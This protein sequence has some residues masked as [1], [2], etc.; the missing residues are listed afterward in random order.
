MKLI[1]GFW[2]DENNN[3]W[4]SRYY[5]EID[6]ETNSNSLTD[7]ENCIDCENCTECIDCRNC[8]NCSYCVDCSD[9]IDCNN[10][11]NCMDSKYCNNQINAT[12]ESFD[13]VG[14]TIDGKDHLF[15]FS[16]M[17]INRNT[18]P[19]GLHLFELRDGGCDGTPYQIARDV[20]VNFF[21]SII[22]DFDVMSLAKEENNGKIWINQDDEEEDFWWFGDY[23]KLDEFTWP[24][25]EKI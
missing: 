4:N 19:D 25:E 21:G 17:R 5:S 22:A 9:C 2:V 16:D 12:K 8:I 23:G 24:L 13:L 11:T 18:I 20:L 6:A 14:C 15:L 3:K 10:C 1:N 7:C